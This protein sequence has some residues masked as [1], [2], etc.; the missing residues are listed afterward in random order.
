VPSSHAAGRW[1]NR[2]GVVV[3]VVGFALTWYTV[4]DTL[5]PDVPLTSFLLGQAPA[6]VAGLGLT[7]FGVGLAVSSREPSDVD[8]VALWCVGGVASMTVV[9]ALTYLGGGMSLDGATESRLVANV[10]VGS[11]VG[12]T[13]IGLRSATTRR[14][15]RSAARQ[16]DRLTVLNRLLRHEVLNRLN[17]VDGYAQG[18]T[19]PTDGGQTVDTRGVIRRN[20]EAIG[21]T[22]ERVGALTRTDDSQPVDVA[23]Q[24]EAAVASVRASHPGRPSRWAT[25]RRRSSS[26]PRTRTCCSSIWS[27][28]RSSGAAGPGRRSG[29][30]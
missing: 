13:L 1:P 27:R 6:L 15:R 22:V 7:A 23:P 29:S 17:V 8:L 16:A 5:R 4:V 10:L 12:G 11:A 25:S 19:D 28:T 21:E 3:G 20:A 18:E 24:L 30:T 9:V 2:G 26:P 14:H